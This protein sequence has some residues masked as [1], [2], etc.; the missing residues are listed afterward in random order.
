MDALGIVLFLGFIFGTI[1]L[2]MNQAKKARET[3]GFGLVFNWS[4]LLVV[5]SLAALLFGAA[6]GGVSGAD[7]ASNALVLKIT[8]V[9]LIGGAGLIN[10]KRSTLPFGIWFTCLQVI[11]AIG[12][13]VPLILL[14]SH[15]RTK[16]VL[17]DIAR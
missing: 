13:I 12:I 17:S 11:A 3:Y 9:V 8:S 2:L 16:S 4:F 15:F 7:H 6:E 1:F 10:V 5:F 14:F